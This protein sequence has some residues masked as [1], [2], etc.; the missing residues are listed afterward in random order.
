MYRSRLDLIAT[1]D[2]YELKSEVMTKWQIIQ[3]HMLEKR[4]FDDHFD[5]IFW[6]KEE[7]RDLVE[8]MLSGT[9]PN[10]ENY[11]DVEDIYPNLSLDEGTSWTF[12]DHDEILKGERELPGENCREY[13]KAER[14]S[15]LRAVR[16]GPEDRKMKSGDNV[17]EEVA[18]SDEEVM[19]V[20]RKIRVTRVGAGPV[21]K[22]S[23]AV[24]VLEDL[25]VGDEVGPRGDGRGTPASKS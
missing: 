18:V 14:Q 7:E 25:M 24:E 19:E 8:R 23:Y 3:L 10:I 6:T 12:K 17:Q 9:E 2:L 20:P 16:I 1:M 4:L 15:K 11:W 13:R 22:I 5:D 21:D